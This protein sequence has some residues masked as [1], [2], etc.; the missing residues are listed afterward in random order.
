MSYTAYGYHGTEILINGKWQWQTYNPYLQGYAKILLEQQAQQ[1][2]AKGVKATV[3]N[4]PEIRTNSSDLFSGV[5]LSLYPLVT[6]L[7]QLGTPP[8]LA[9]LKSDIS[10]LLKPEFSLEQLLHNVNSYHGSSV[11]QEFYADFSAWPRHNSAELAELMLSVSDAVMAMNQDRKKVVTDLLSEVV[12]QSTG[13]LM[14]NEAF[15]PQHPVCWIGH[16][17]IARERHA[18]LG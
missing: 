18:R 17:V 15:N 12:V 1:A 6:A 14:I 4:C 16:D 9:Q 7:E 2:W 11:P 5:E 13:H 10:A 8:W 3:F